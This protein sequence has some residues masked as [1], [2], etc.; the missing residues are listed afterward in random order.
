MTNNESIIAMIN[1]KLSLYTD[2]YDM[3]E[4]SNNI[5][6]L[7][8]MNNVEQV[9]YILSQIS[10][11]LDKKKLDSK[12][13]CE[14]YSYLLKLDNNYQEKKDLDKRLKYL[15]K[16]NLVGAKESLK[17]NHKRLKDT[18]LTLLPY[19][20][21]NNIDY[22]LHGG[23]C[24]Y[25]NT[26]QDFDRYHNNVDVFINNDDLLK[27]DSCL[28]N[29]SFNI[30]DERLLTD[31]K[32]NYK[33]GH[34]VGRHNHGLYLT[35]DEMLPVGLFLFQREPDDSITR[36]SYYRDNDDKVKMFLEP[37]TPEQTKLKYSNKK[38][39]Y[40][41]QTYKSATLENMYLIKKNME[42]K[43]KHDAEYIKPYLNEYK[44]KSLEETN[45]NVKEPYTEE[46]KNVLSIHAVKRL[47]K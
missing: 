41:N 13:V 28:K 12:Q 29:S 45:K 47:I 44:L 2:N 25:L 9:D 42:P 19:L 38:Q 21:D 17:D 30:Q 20:E 43:D 34:L 7:N 8:D 39:H 37:E 22:Y 14:I 46:P 4:I 33:T 31:A 3:N 32:L 1:Y 26:N 10:I 27:L 16:M 24:C 36:I 23:V 40:F 6:K 18:L 5:K 35:S 15:Q 11:N